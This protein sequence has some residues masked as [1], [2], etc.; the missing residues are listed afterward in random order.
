LCFVSDGRKKPQRN[1]Q[2]PKNSGNES[3]IGVYDEVG[4]PLLQSRMKD[5]ESLGS[6]FNR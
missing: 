3:F 1:I 5:Q 2:L 6:N 4:F